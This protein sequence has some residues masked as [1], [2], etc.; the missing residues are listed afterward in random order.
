MLLRLSNSDIEEY[1]KSL[2]KQ[3][4]DIKEEIFRLAWY[5]R[6]SVNSTDLFHLYSN[7][8][9]LIISEIVKENIE[10]TKKSGMPII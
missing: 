6:G 7:E 9:R 2:E 3:S 5:M 10:I 1:L 8:D 4:K